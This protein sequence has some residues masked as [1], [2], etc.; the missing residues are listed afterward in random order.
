MAGGF[1]TGAGY[2]FKG[3][4]MLSQ[5]GLRRFIVVPLTLN[6]VLFSLL[7]WQGFGWIDQA[8]AYGLSWIPDWLSFLSWVM[9][10]LLFLTM[11]IFVFYT[12]SIVANLIASPFNGLLSEK[13]ET[14]FLPPATN[15]SLGITG[16]LALVPHSLSREASKLLYFLP[17]ALVLLVLTLIPGINLFAIPAW[18]L[19]SAWFLAI[20]YCDYPTDNHNIS[21]PELRALLGKK[22]LCS[23][24]FG[25]ITLL[26]T[27]IPIV[28]LVVIPAAV[29]GATLFWM[30]EL[31]ELVGNE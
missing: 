16:I 1:V 9:W 24:G 30:E 18:Y 4:K 13:T 8:V 6:V 3:F 22:R 2:L 31:K 26:F 27:M 10:P 25:S 21:V 23:F 14:Q 29:I 5:P 15:S 28:N 12:F 17:R 20:Q 19:F 7:I 11:M